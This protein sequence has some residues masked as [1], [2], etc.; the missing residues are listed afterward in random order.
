[1]PELRAQRLLTAKL[2][3]KISGGG[4]TAALQAAINQLQPGDELRITKGTYEGVLDINV[5]GTPD[6]PITVRSDTPQGATFTGASAFNITGAYITVADFRFAQT[7]ANVI[8]LEGKRTKVLNNVFEQCGDGKSGASDGIVVTKN[9]SAG[10]PTANALGVLTSAPSVEQQNLIAGNKF[11]QPKNT[12]YWQDHGMIGNEFSFNNIEGPHGMQAN[13]ETEAIKI[14]YSFGTDETK[15]RVVFNTISN[16]SGIPY[17]IGI[18]SNR[19]LVGY[20]LLSG[21]IQLRYGNNN[22]VIGNVILDGD[23]HVG[24]SGHL[25]KFN[26]VRTITPRDNYGPFAPFYTS[27][28][29]KQ[30][31]VSPTI[32]I[33]SRN[34]VLKTTNSFRL[35]PTTAQ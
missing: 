30:Y 7:G 3:R 25:I 19:T 20:N 24:G 5:S 27:T 22:A 9:L 10:W 35:L 23:L 16:W 17:T 31:G 14:G 33:V 15:T 2:I 8:R 21:R 26:V 29:T 12:V 32:S 4:T 18:K 28:I 6:K 34:R 13:F 11:L 1:M